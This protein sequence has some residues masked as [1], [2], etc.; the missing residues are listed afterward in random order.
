MILLCLSG[1]AV[2]INLFRNDLFQTINSYDDKKPVGTLY[3]RDNNVQRRMGDRVLWGRLVK[4]SPIY[5]DDLIRVAELSAAT[6][7][8]DGNYI[9][10]NENTLIRVQ[11]D[12]DN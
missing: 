3:I 4:E 12:S 2:S 1:A 11:R 5:L 9:N 6:L 8:I 10:L 7:D